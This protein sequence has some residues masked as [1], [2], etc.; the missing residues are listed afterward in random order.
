[1]DPNGGTMRDQAAVM[2]YMQRQRAGRHME[3]GARLEREGRW[4][5]AM[6]E[7]KNA[8]ELDP[9]LIDAHFALGYHYR[10]KGLLL[11]ASDA[12]RRAAVLSD[13]YDSWFN[14]G[15]TLTDLGRHTEAED[16]FKRCLVLRPGDPAAR[17]EL[18]FT[19]YNS[20]Q[21]QDALGLLGTLLDEY[22][23]DW[24]LLLLRGT[25]QLSLSE[26]AAAEADFRR[27]LPNAPD[28]EARDLLTDNVSVASRYQEFPAGEL[29]NQK[30]RLYA[31]YGSICLGAQGDDGLAIPE[32]ES[33]RLTFSDVAIMIRR[34]K[35]VLRGLRLPPTVVVPAHEEA[36]PIAIVAASLLRARLVPL[37]SLQG[38]DLPLVVVGTCTR[39]ELYDLILE[40]SESDPVV[41][42]AT[43]SWGG[44]G[45][46]MPD[47]VGVCTRQP[48]ALPW[49]PLPEWAA[50]ESEDDIPHWLESSPAGEQVW[51]L[52]EQVFDALEMLPKESVRAQIAYYTEKHRQ[53]RVCRLGGESSS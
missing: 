28:D 5:E 26:Y 42:A 27:A 25:C 2:R 13:D 19:Y 12:Y 45:E 9:Q 14:L 38:W 15:H 3:R 44:K 49:E 1:M 7:F 10:R 21:H 53:L 43:V 29:T 20:G 52:S 8:V 40:R 46:F 16:V 47:I 35:N 22:P 37:N 51:Q 41:F 30:D 31:D 50:V 33:L 23:E 39:V 36:L 6:A 11:K 4:E 32:V 34:L 48:S 24:E 17:Y 18:A